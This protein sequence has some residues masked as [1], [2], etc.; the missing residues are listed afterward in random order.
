MIAFAVI[1]LLIL[2]FLGYMALG[3]WLLL[4]KGL[5][6]LSIAAIV[7]A[8]FVSAR[9]GISLPAYIVASLLRLKS[10]SSINIGDT[11]AAM[12]KEIWTR[13][14]AFTFVQPLE[15]WV[16]A[17]DPHPQAGAR[18]PVL[19]VHGYVC[20][21]GIW[22][23]MRRLLGERVPNPLFTTNLEPPFARIDDYVPLLA[24]RV[25]EIC[26]AAGSDKIVIIAHSMGGLVARAYLARDTGAE[27][28][29]CLVTIASPHHGTAMARLGFGRNVKQMYCGNAWLATLEEDEKRCRGAMP[30]TCIYSEDD[31]LVFPANSCRL[32]DANNIAL[33]GV[34]HV[35]LLYSAHVADLIAQEIIAAS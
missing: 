28:V 12:G 23:A 4:V 7:L 21:R 1:T 34:G 2:E 19:L 22:R 17:P 14:L 27:R 3:V 10:H 35:S 32:P 8:V 18:P 26:A 9:I 31:D 20:N 29:A 30:V 11:L 24:A 6:F 5:G 15:K 16:M 25:D 33:R 13:S